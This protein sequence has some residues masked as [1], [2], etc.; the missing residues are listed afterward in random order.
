MNS[1]VNKRLTCGQYTV[2][3]YNIQ[4]YTDPVLLRRNQYL[5]LTK[6]IY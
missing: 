1:S 5:E 6:L 3:V 2:D 4:L